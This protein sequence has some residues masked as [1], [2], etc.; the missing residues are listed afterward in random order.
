MQGASERLDDQIEGR[1]IG[2]TGAT[3]IG[4][5][6]IVGGGI[7]ALAGVAFATAGPSALVA[8]A[9]NG[10]IALLTALVFAELA[11]SF[12]ESGGT[13]TFAKKVL[14]V[15]AAFIVGW[16]VWFAS[17]VAAVLYALGFGSFAAL[18][19]EALWQATGGAAPAWL[20]SGLVESLLALAATGLYTAGLLRKSGGGGQW[21]TIGKVVVFVVLI[22][23]G[24]WALPQRP[25]TVLRDD[26][27]PFFAFGALGL[28]QAMGYTFIALQGFDLIAAVGGEV[29]SPTKTL[30]RAMIASLVIALL[31]YLPLLFV[32]STVGT[33]AGVD[34]AAVAASDPEAVVA[35]AAEQYLGR[36]GFWL[37]LVAALLSMLSALQANL[38]AAS[39][40][41]LAMARDRNLPGR[42]RTLDLRRGIPTAAVWTTSVTTAL[43]LLVVPDVAAAGAVSSL[44]FLLSFALAHWTSILVRRRGGGRADAVRLPLFPLIPGV[45]GLA[46]LGL[47]MFQGVAVPA[48]GVLGGVWLALGFGLYMVVFSRRARVADAAA[49]ALD[50]QLVR[51]RG[52]SPLVLVPIARPSS[53]EALV[54][55]AHALAPPHVGRVL[56]L[57][58]VETPTTWRPDEPP[59]QLL[60]AQQV[61]GEALT[62]SFA[63]SL[64][65]QALTTVAREPWQEIA[66]VASLYRCESLLLGVGDL[67]SVSVSE[68]E[69]L[70]SEV[71]S[72]IVL[73]HA[74]AAWTL[75][76]VRRVLVPVG[77]RRDQ[78]GARARLVG[79]LC[80]ALTPELVYL[81]LVPT[82]TGA[83]AQR[84]F[85]REVTM[86]ADDEGA[87]GA[88]HVVVEA[89]DDVAEAVAE[90]A[91]EVDLVILGLSRLGGR[92]V[93]SKVAM[94]AARRTR[95][96]VMLISAA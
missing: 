90:Q 85:E 47:A 11:T 72:D 26:L 15:E 29:R 17:I 69:H 30:P 63:A 18:T 50:P 75:A 58:V 60:F 49:E 32:L 8:F 2:L 3:L 80:R 55:V 52:R 64:E 89:R 41:A 24:L 59:P 4:V 82:T 16:V 21:E 91:A 42:L 94:A 93:F 10:V 79:S 45:A 1:S 40:I 44:I 27:D 81:G 39:R 53:A 74:P 9:A 48:A 5:G 96:A 28:V 65:P 36:T 84:Q 56:L 54:T 37:V 71:E 35:I 25:M 31:I 51:L 19:V 61:L 87:G 13:Y 88:V 92:R 22:A 73:L 34:I 70:M 77:G 68:L 86:L 38:F 43:I 46:C 95:G 7:L 83:E 76:T 14:S 12:P 33:P 20:R 6:A 66:R 67:E 78:S 23:G 62:A 57:S